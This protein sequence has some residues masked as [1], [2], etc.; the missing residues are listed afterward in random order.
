VASTVAAYNG[1]ISNAISMV[2]EQYPGTCA[3]FDANALM[4]G[5]EPAQKTH[6]LLLLPQAGG[7]VATAAGMTYFSLDG[8][9]PNQK[10]Y[11]V[12]ANGVLEVINDL[13]G[14]SYPMVDISTLS[15]DPTYGQTTGP[16]S[17]SPIL[18]RDAAVAMENMF[19]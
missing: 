5:L 11:G 17:G 15:W 18:T 7:D 13:T 3:L 19:R 16:V 1:A 10:G 6:F 8:V 12:V 14:S 4:A 9:H 2:N